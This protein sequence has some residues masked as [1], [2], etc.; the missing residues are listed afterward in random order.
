MNPE[1]F[2]AGGGVVGMGLIAVQ[3]DNLVF[4]RVECPG[5]DMDGAGAFFDEHEEEAV[6]G[7][8]VQT[9]IGGVTEMTG[10]YGVEECF[11]C[12]SAGGVD[13]VIGIAQNSGF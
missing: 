3:H 13:I 2:P 9:V 10:T 4:C 12:L 1:G 5:V 7:I 11:C 6:V 8:P